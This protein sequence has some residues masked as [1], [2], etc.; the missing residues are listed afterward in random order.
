LVLDVLPY[1]NDTIFASVCDSFV[2]NGNI[3][4]TSG[5]YIDTFATVSGCDSIEVLDLT[6]NNSSTSPLNLELLLD[7]YCAETHWTI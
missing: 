4:T 3:Y 2:W 6:F 1:Y 7:D 5:I